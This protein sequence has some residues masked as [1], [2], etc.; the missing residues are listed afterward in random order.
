MSDVTNAQVATVMQILH[1]WYALCRTCL[2][3]SALVQPVFRATSWSSCA[4]VLPSISMATII[5]DVFPR[6]H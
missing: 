4:I 6:W 3:R 2:V 5:L 1:R